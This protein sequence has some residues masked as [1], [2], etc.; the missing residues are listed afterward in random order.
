MLILAVGDV[1]GKP[2]RQALARFLP[3]IKRQYGVD[4]TIVNAENVA[5]GIGVTPDTAADLIDAGAD[6]LTSGNHVW[7]QKDILPVLDGEMP[8]LRPLNYPPGVPGRGYLVSRGVMVVNLIGRTFIGNFECPFRTMDS[9]LEQVQNKPPIIVVDFHAEATSEKVALGRYLDGRV[10]AVLGTHTHVGTIDAQ[11][12]SR[13][14]AYVTDIGMTG[15]VNS[16]IGDDADNVIQRFLTQLPHRMSAGKGKTVLNAILVRVDDA[17][18][19]ATAI[20]RI[21]KET[22]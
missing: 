13:G 14:T 10:S 9:L 8:L 5:G 15:P 18:G 20:E 6:V 21:Q 4:F 11:I 2:G 19:R 3:E 22:D 12:L 17:T 7:A 1:I 16:I